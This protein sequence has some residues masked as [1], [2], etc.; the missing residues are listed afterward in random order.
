MKKYVLEINEESLGVLAKAC[1]FYS[2]AFIL[3]YKLIY[4]V[5]VA[6]KYE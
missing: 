2:I 4:G 3:K 6:N 1:E 5:L